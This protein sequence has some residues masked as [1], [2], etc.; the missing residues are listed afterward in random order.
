MTA[1]G[2][3]IVARAEAASARDRILSRIRGFPDSA[4]YDEILR[5]LAFARLV[6]RGLADADRG[7]RLD[8]AELKR[9]IRSWRR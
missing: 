8:S 2:G 1:A 9:R 5:E 3:P 4:S 6:D 7:R